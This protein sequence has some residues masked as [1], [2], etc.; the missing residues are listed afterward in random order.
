MPPLQ[1]IGRRDLARFRSLLNTPAPPVLP[2]TASAESE[3]PGS[4]IG[5]GRSRSK[6]TARQPASTSTARCKA[7][8]ISTI[9]TTPCLPYVNRLVAHA[10]WAKA[11]L[12]TAP[13]H[14]LLQQ[15]LEHI[16][17]A[18]RIFDQEAYALQRQAYLEFRQPS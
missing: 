18:L 7:G 14:T 15:A 2:F 5:S 1:R 10:Y 12:Q 11:Q 16:D 8:P 9:P 4:S 3:R 17:N 6:K 13:T